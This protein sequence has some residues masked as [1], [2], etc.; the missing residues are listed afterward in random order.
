MLL[1]I[2]NVLF[3]F[4]KKQNWWRAQV[5]L[6]MRCFQASCILLGGCTTPL[7]TNGDCGDCNLIVIHALWLSLRPVSAVSPTL[8]ALVRWRS[9]QSS[10]LIQLMHNWSWMMLHSCL[11]SHHH[12]L[13]DVLNYVTS[14]QNFYCHW[15]FP[16]IHEDHIFLNSRNGI[17]FQLYLMLGLVKNEHRNTSK[18]FGW[19][20]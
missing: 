10:T 14:V 15:K 18:T 11:S 3:F 20:W 6:C 13:T 17:I 16:M 7:L 12:S 4:L 9:W 2:R 1:H 19:L 8:A 5:S